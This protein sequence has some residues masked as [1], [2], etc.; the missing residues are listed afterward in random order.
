LTT[1]FAFEDLKVYQ[2]F[3]RLKWLNESTFRSLYLEAE[4]I[5]KMLSGLIN[6][7]KASI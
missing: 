2:R 7:I 6:S 5:N 1:A 3:R 4:E